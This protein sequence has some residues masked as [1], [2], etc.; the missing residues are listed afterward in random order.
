MTCR[1]G[2][3]D[4]VA[5]AMALLAVVVLGI[6]IAGVFFASSQEIQTGRN[7]VHQAQALA[8]SEHG[9]AMM[10]S[11]WNGS[12]ATELPV[13]SSIHEPVSMQEGGSIGITLTRLTPTTYWVVSE[14]HAGPSADTRR[15]TGILLRLAIPDLHPLGALAVRSSSGTPGGELI[16]GVVRID[17]ADA[18]PASWSDCVPPGPSAAGIASDVSPSSGAPDGPCQSD[19]CIRGSPP[20]L[21]DA[22]IAD[23]TR[24][25]FSQE[26]WASLTA[27]ANLLL[28]GGS[29]VGSPDRPVQP[30]VREERCDITAPLNWGDPSRTTACAS[31]FPVIHVL[32]DLQ[33]LGG[34]GQGTLLVDGDLTI[35]GGA[36]FIGAVFVRGA[37]RTG[38]G[39]A[40]LL[41]MTRVGGA[42]QEP[43]ALLDGAELAFSR[44]AVL[45]ALT[46]GA[47]PEILPRS[48]IEVR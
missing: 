25:P 41:G 4:G 9:L 2:R 43:S 15:S 42:S 14:A 5:M 35:S 34:I 40:R 33:M 19:G 48:W 13:G 26:A 7:L 10:L 16:Q 38:A 1:L 46:A 44:C 36:H 47:S 27:R 30:R 21:I 29:V 28:P 20:V 32:G 18:G 3:R 11:A 23:S 39:G 24:P 6:V 8:R 12:W 37:L 17:G 22:T 31:Y 45:A